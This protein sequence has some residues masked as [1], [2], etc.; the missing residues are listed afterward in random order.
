MKIIPHL[1]PDLVD[2]FKTIRGSNIKTQVPKILHFLETKCKYG[3][4][5]DKVHPS[6]LTS[7]PY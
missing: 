6:P 1:D 5:L 2:F 3:V 4:D 7:G